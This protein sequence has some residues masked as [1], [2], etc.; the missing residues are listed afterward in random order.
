MRTVT[1]LALFATSIVAF[2]QTPP[3]F[4]DLVRGSGFIFQGTVKAIGEATPSVVKQPNTAVVTVDRVIEA[5][6]PVTNLKPREVT[7]R[8]RDP[9]KIKA[10]YAATFFTYVYSAGETL[11]LEEVGTQPVENADVLSRRVREARQALADEALSKRLSTAQFVIVG[12]L[13]PAADS[14]AAAR[15]PV[16]E[17][18][19]MWRAMPV[20]AESFEKGA[21]TK[22]PP[23]VYVSTS[24]D[25]VWERAPKPKPGEPGI[26]L[27]Q[28]SPGPDH[29]SGLSGLFLVDP[30]DAL[31][32]SELER[33]RRLLKTQR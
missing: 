11:G 6:P 5:L 1:L 4:N 31:P 23:V 26:F 7:V 27:L 17:H 24:T 22:E 28:P 2:G 25:V 9:G 16:S 3:S 32:R 8:L 21:K 33:V 29:W 30:L 10:G 12:A 18:D 13:E 19:P 20:R 14:K 15:E